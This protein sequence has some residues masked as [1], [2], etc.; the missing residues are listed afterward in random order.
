MENVGMSISDKVKSIDNK[1]NRYPGD[2]WNEQSRSTTRLPFDYMSEL[3]AGEFEQEDYNDYGNYNQYGKGGKWIQKATAS[4]KR[5]GTAGK[6]TPMTKPGC[7]GRALALAKTFHK[8]VRNRKKKEDG[9]LIM[10]RGGSMSPQKVAMILAEKNP[11]LQKHPITDAQRRWLYWIKNKNNKAVGGNILGAMPLVGSAANIGYSLLDKPDKVN[12]ERVPYEEMTP[13]FLDP[14]QQIRDIETTYAGA[15][16]GIR[17]TSPQNYLNRISALSSSKTRDMGKVREQYAN[18]NVGITNEMKEANKRYKTY[19]DVRN[20][21]IQRM[22]AI[23]RARDEQARE[24]AIMG[25]VSSLFTQAGQVGRDINMTEANKLYNDEMFKVIR[26]GQDLYRMNKPTVS[27]STTP[28]NKYPFSPMNIT[29]LNTDLFEGYNSMYTGEEF[30]PI[31][32][33]DK[34]YRQ[35]LLSNRQRYCGGGRLKKLSRK[36]K[37]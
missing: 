15:T 33:W 32:D 23:D 7:T 35:S 28:V 26:E 17:R 31:P 12:Y 14:T 13:T 9:G 5:R 24:N 1:F 22:E 34:N 19:V 11:T 36:R 29:P 21:E 37:R 8:M 16:E 27:P 18:I 3:I 25:N 2:M 10:G 6:C 4:I 20:A 30:L